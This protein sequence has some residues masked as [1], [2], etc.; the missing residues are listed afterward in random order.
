METTCP[1]KPTLQQF[2]EL[3]RNREYIL[4]DVEDLQTGEKV[5]F[6][7]P[8]WGDLFCEEIGENNVIHLQTRNPEHPEF[9]FI[10]QSKDYINSVR[11]TNRELLF[12]RKNFRKN[13][14][15]VKLMLNKAINVNE[16]KP[17]DKK[18]NIG[19]ISNAGKD[20]LGNEDL[21]RYM[22]GPFL[23]PTPSRKGG[24][25]KTRAKKN[26]RKRTRRIRRKYKR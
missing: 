4:V 7:Q 5:L 25:R 9:E 15:D 13:F 3:Y 16:N 19:T 26:K 18:K 11:G 12:F 1:P 14:N 6:T 21:T 17:D 22:I 10:N 8:N 23:G 20:V 24:R 2:D